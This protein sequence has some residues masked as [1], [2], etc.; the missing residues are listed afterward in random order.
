MDGP[1]QRSGHGP[2][3][4]RVAAQR[5]D[6][7]EPLLEA[8][9]LGR[10]LQP[11]PRREQRESHVGP[12]DPTGPTRLDDEVL[13]LLAALAVEHRRHG[14]LDRRTGLVPRTSAAVAS[15]T[16]RHAVRHRSSQCVIADSSGA[17]S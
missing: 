15:V 11:D 16:A 5:D 2:V 14:V 3:R 9:R 7:A 1:Q 4:V 12:V 10:H 8:R 6:A 13:E 17:S